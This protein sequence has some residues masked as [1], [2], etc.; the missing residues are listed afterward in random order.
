LEA[1]FRPNWLPIFVGGLLVVGGLTPVLEGL[2]EAADVCGLS[3]QAIACQPAIPPLAD[4]PD[5]DHAPATPST[6]TTTVTSTAAATSN[7]MT[8]TTSVTGLSRGSTR[9]EAR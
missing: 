5:P 7:R 9:L 4:R 8:P 1:T 2:K 6:I 3:H